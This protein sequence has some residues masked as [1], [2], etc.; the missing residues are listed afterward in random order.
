MLTC[1]GNLIITFTGINVS[2]IHVFMFQIY[3][4]NLQCIVVVL[5]PFFVV[6]RLSTMFGMIY[7]FYKE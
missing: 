5:N 3:V 2:L 4:R 1:L 7:I 6:G